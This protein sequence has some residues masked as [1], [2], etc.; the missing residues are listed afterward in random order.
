MQSSDIAQKLRLFIDSQAGR[1]Y[2]WEVFVLPTEITS[3]Q[4]SLVFYGFTLAGE[5]RG[6]ERLEV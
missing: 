4:S 5:S 1:F 3:A 2:G 6:K